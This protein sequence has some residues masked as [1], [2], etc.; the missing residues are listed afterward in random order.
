MVSSPVLG[1]PEKDTGDGSGF[2]GTRP[3]WHREGERHGRSARMMSQVGM[4]N[5]VMLISSAVSHA[6][7]WIVYLVVTFSLVIWPAWQH[8]DGEDLRVLATVFMP[9]AL[10][11]LG[12]LT[13]LDQGRLA[14]G[15][16]MLIISAALLTVFCGLA[17]LS[18]ALIHLPVSAKVT[19]GL[20]VGFY[21][22]ILTLGV[23]RGGRSLLL[24]IT[25][26][27]LLGFSALA[28]FSVGIFFLPAALAMLV[29]AVASL[30][31][32]SLPRTCRNT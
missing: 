10:T 16:P 30:L 28:A 24:G 17:I 9:V 5:K 25:V 6:L 21:P 1:L 2:F 8:G 14:V 4:S 15:Q 7:A 22:I 23:G 12:L 26:A 31:T 29:A 32:R 18:I 3:E 27:L 19:I 11:G 20:I 13:V